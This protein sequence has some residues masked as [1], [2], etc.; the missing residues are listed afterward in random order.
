[1][2]ASPMSPGAYWR[3]VRYNGNFRRLWGAQ[4]VSE[5]GDWLYSLAIYS[6]LLELTGRANAV[7]LAVVLQVLPAAFAG[8]T[9]GVV[10][11][12]IPRKHVMIAA[13]LG[14][15]AIVLGM[16]L[17]RT[18]EMVWFVYP[19]LFLETVLAAFFEPARSAVIPN[20]VRHG[21]VMIANTLSSTTWSFN[22][23]VGATLGGL[24]AVAF[25]RDTVFVLNAA[26][27]LLSALLIRRMHF[28]EPH[29][30]GAGPL[31]FRDLVDYSPVLEGI[32]YIRSDA[33]VL[34]TVF[35]KAGLGF[36]GANLVLLPLLGERIFPVHW[37]GIDAQRGGMLGMSMLMGARGVGALI[38][39]FV[40]GSWAG[41]SA[42]R[43]RRGILIG[44]LAASTGYLL[45]SVSPT[46]WLAMAAVA[47]AHGGGSTIWVFSTSLLQMYTE[48]RFRGR[49]FSAEFALLMV[50][51][52]MTSYVASLAIDWGAPVRTWAMVTG[53]SILLPAAAWGYVQRLWRKSRA[54]VQVDRLPESG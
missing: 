36:L 14:R 11:D 34:A 5:I 41:N 50:T 46:V 16:L 7:G 38:G 21:E 17:V 49:V 8:P 37:P 25:G 42:S 40:S 20:I 45:I 3:L 27:F 44:F 43:L 52:A 1:M 47:L 53:I 24:I 6:L 10:N 23:A 29:A 22:L 9:A 30:S 19:L 32:R 48:D 26:S 35:V 4:I 2:G 15:A 51:I 18:R 28:D 39:P 12:R 13:D 31:Q 33:R 54:G